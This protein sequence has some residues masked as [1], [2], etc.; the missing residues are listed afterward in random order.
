MMADTPGGTY[1]DDE[2]PSDVDR[3]TSGSPTPPP[4]RASVRQA[5]ESTPHSELKK[6]VTKLWRD[7]EGSRALIDETIRRPIP[8]SKKRK[9]RA[10]ELCHHCQEHYDVNQ[11]IVG[12][13]RYHDGDREVDDES[14][15]WIDHDPDCHG[16]PSDLR[17]MSDPVY[18]DGYIMSCCDRRPYELGCV[19]SRHKPEI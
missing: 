14:E 15:T 2:L 8:G 7:L 16:D 9:R 4:Q 13:C 12:S 10:F 11:N 18:E 5:I 19:I 17:L 6:L 3:E 1:V